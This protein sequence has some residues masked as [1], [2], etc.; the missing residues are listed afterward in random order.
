MKYKFSLFA[1]FLSVVVCNA[2]AEEE[3]EKTGKES[4]ANHT[5]TSIEPP[6]YYPVYFGVPMT[7][8]H[9]PHGPM[10]QFPVPPF[11]P[12]GQASMPPMGL[13]M[14]YMPTRMTPGH[15]MSSGHPMSPGH[16]MSTGHPMSSGHHM[17]A[18]HPMS[19]GHSMPL[20]NPV[21]HYHQV[22]HHH[23]AHFAETSQLPVYTPISQYD[24][25]FSGDMGHF[26]DS[27]HDYAAPF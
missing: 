3:T 15:P 19:S 6:K 26:D 5:S 1:A 10:P 21:P 11:H 20:G 16:P 17:S 12:S 2:V 18:G 25:G 27:D 7:P 22:P 24:S 9:G 8:G 14:P 13:G 23:G 4:S